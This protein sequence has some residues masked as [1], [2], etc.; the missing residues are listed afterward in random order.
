[1][2]PEIVAI[3]NTFI[4]Y[5]SAWHLQNFINQLDV[6]LAQ[7]HEAARQHAQRQAEES[8]RQLAQRQAEEA[9]RQLAQ[10]QA[11]E[12][13]RLH[14]QRQA[15]EIARQLAQRKAEEA[16]QLGARQLAQ[17]QAEAAAYALAQR[18]AKEAALE[19]I[20]LALELSTASKSEAAGTS[21]NIGE[22]P[23]P[24]ASEVSPVKMIGF[25][26]GPAAMAKIE[27]ATLM[28][29]HSIDSA[30]AQYASAISPYLNGP[31]IAANAVR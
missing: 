24:R 18:K 7:L 26:P 3:V 19:E 12:A 1:M 9:A 8:A 13:A 4:A 14:A 22:V 20:R 25:I 6:V 23:A 31:A 10:R 28:L 29:K 15:E 21:T 2:S 5:E 17:Q 16:A 30:V 11:E 27:Q